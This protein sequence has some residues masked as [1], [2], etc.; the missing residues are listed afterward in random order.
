MNLKDRLGQGQAADVSY[1]KNDEIAVGDEVEIFNIN[2]SV[3]SIIKKIIQDEK[4][5]LIQCKNS[6]EREI[7]CNYIRKYM[8]YEVV[9]VLRELTQDINYS[10]A[11]RLIITEPTEKDII[12]LFEKMMT[13]YKSYIFPINLRS[14]EKIT[15]SLKALIMM[16]KS[17]ITENVAEHI[18]GVSDIAI[19]EITRNEDGLFEI[20]KI[21]EIE[22]NGDK[23]EAKVIYEKHEEISPHI[24]QKAETENTKI[25]QRDEENL[26]PEN[27]KEESEKK[28]NKINLLKLKAKKKKEI[29]A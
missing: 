2:K 24:E 6:V 23:V 28:L 27:K 5:I 12:R 13:D 11:N 21:E 16:N 1:Q 15:E 19:I 14:G 8:S 10:K 9:D 26:A 4:N 17:N 25:V 20:G 29:K 22:Y 18:I 3:E 7:T